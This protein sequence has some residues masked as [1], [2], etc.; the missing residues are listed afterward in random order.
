ML[1]QTPEFLV[2]MGIV[3]LA[4]SIVRRHS[5]QIIIL[6]I[7]SYIFYMGWDWRYLFL[8]LFSTFNAY[9]CG[10]QIQL[11]PS[12]R[13]RRAW[14][15]TAIVLDLALLAF[16]KYGNFAISS[17]NSVLDWTG[18]Y[19]PFSL[20]EDLV[21]PV[22]ISF[23]TFHTIGYCVDVY[24]GD[25]EAEPSLLRFS[26]FVAFFPQLVAG[27]ILR[28]THF[29]PQIRDEVTLRAEN[30]R[31][32]FNL[33]LIGL[34]KKVLIADHIAPLVNF[35]F[36]EPQGLPSIFILLGALGFGIQIYC[37]FSGY[38][39]IAIGVGRMIGFDIS[40]NFNYPYAARTITDFWR[41]WHI[42][43]S[44][45]LRDYLY[46]PL[47]GNRHGK[48]NTY[49]NLM[50]TMTL[51]GLWH[52]AAWNFVIWGAY[53]GALLAVERLLG[54]GSERTSSSLA[55]E[56]APRWHTWRRRAAILAGW[57]ITQYLVFLGWL[58]FRVDNFQDLAY[59]VRKY[60][61]FDFDT[62]LSALGAGNVNPFIA[63]A[64][65]GGFIVLH[66]WSYRMGSFARCMDAMSW[67]LR[68]L[69]YLIAFLA[70]A[71]LWPANTV[72]FIYFQF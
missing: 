55:T 29:L 71:T 4:M 12:V 64:M 26:L 6:L 70:L 2:L 56:H 20:I 25:A 5:W 43:L 72:S 60:L 1:F 33:S 27:P 40:K 47:G 13:A 61:V 28:S 50:I 18:N 11:R 66:A 53:Q 46:V 36:E 21:V 19:Q 32:G 41:R 68:S 37:D 48:F 57:A 38:T 31:S 30:L 22:G 45:W 23:Y 69:I 7:A 58:I 17:L 15:T 34:V 42:S 14:L 62:R 16:F 52:G 49:R 3:L 9:F 24:R 54:R 8:L 51:G 59:C 35:V 10:L 63:L 65:I 39:D 44:T 67:P